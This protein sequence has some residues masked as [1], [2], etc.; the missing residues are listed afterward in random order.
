MGTLRLGP[1]NSLPRVSGYLNVQLSSFAQL[2]SFIM[3][4]LPNIREFDDIDLAESPSNS[5]E[6]LA[7]KYDEW[8]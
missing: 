4:S 8:M 2:S 6:M 5:E 1:R 3:L 7:L